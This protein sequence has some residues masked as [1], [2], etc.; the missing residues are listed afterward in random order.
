MLANV[1]VLLL[2][3]EDGVDELLQ[4]RDQNA[5]GSIE[6]AAK[7]AFRLT[8]PLDSMPWLIRYRHTLD[9]TTD[10]L[11]HDLI[12]CP[13]LIL[14]V[15]TATKEIEVPEIILQE[16]YESNHVLPSAYKRGLYDPSTVRQEVLVLHDNIEGG[17]NNKN[18]AKKL[19]RPYFTTRLKLRSWEHHI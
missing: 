4:E 6:E 18:E 8:S 14:L 10:G 1:G 3:L 13:P 7:D 9:R 19:G 2:L 15:C 17:F 11:P 5:D 12:C 16:L